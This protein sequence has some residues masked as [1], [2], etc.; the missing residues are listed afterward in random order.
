MQG[1]R[2]FEGWLSGAKTM[3]LRCPEYDRDPFRPAQPSTT[4]KARRRYEPVVSS[5]GQ[6]QG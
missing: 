6:R 2:S 4:L 3:L 5:Q 1:V